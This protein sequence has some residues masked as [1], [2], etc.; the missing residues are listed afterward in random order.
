MVFP[1]R[2]TGRAT[3]PEKS[4]GI[5]CGRMIV[6]MFQ[7][8]FVKGIGINRLTMLMTVSGTAFGKMVTI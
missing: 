5:L 1:N 7:G 4:C 3:K 6:T 2:L 8:G